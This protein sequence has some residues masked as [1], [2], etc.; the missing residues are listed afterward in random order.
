ML[1]LERM[2]IGDYLA[3]VNNFRRKVEAENAALKQAQR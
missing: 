3:V 1:A 2:A